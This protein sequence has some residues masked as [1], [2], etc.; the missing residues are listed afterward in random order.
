MNGLALNHKR[1]LNIFSIT[2]SEGS[3]I[4]VQDTAYP[5]DP[6]GDS[7]FYSSYHAADGLTRY[8]NIY[9]ED[10]A[11]PT[12]DQTN[13]IASISVNADRKYIDW[14]GNSD[15]STQYVV[16][17]VDYQGNE[18]AAINV[19]RTVNQPATGMYTLT[20][21]NL[22][23]IQAP[24]GLGRKNKLEFKTFLKIEEAS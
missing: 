4:G 13:R 5:S 12:I 19:E 20:W 21:N 15:G 16:T 6:G 8:Y 22:G 1:F 24:L 11:T 23:E 9:A 17:A 14:L 10:G 7:K 18:S 2:V 3:G